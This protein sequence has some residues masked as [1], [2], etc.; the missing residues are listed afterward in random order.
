MRELIANTWL[1]RDLNP[2]E[3]DALLPLIKRG[4]AGMGAPILE[5]N[6]KNDALWIIV[7][8]E[9]GVQKTGA[10]A[11]EYVA[12][13]REGDLFGE[14]SWLDGQ[15]ASVTLVAAGAGTELLRLSFRDFDS[16]LWER[17]D[18]HINILRKFAINLSHRLRSR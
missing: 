7:K 15:P 8:G 10:A 16:F 4:S 6:K 14:M 3:I 5:Q 13:L 9:V 12:R 1:L 11:G 17:P 2:E 18:A